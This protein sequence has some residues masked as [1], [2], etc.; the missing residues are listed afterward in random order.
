MRRI[1]AATLVTCALVFGVAAC[2]G[3][4]GAE[5]EIP[6]ATTPAATESPAGTA[7]GAAVF[8]DNCAGCHGSDGGGGSAPAIRGEDDL[9]EI[10]DQVESGGGSM[11]A[12]S[13]QLTAAEIE[14][15]AGYVATELK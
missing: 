11:P 4:D 5:P 10:T 1:L 6:A 7:D 12:F 15:V 9:A 2:G 14:A 13:G 3:D 8:A